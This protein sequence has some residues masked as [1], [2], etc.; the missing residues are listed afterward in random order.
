MTHFID[1]EID[2]VYI[3]ISAECVREDFFFLSSSL[4]KLLIIILLF[5]R[6]EKLRRFSEDEWIKSV[7]SSGM[8]IV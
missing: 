4:E 5:E 2:V 8:D 6:E 7:S 3:D 1:N